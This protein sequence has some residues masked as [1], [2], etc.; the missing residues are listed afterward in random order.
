MGGKDG[1]KDT[2]STPKTL[3]ITKCPKNAPTWIENTLELC[4]AVGGGDAKWVG[5]V[6]IWM[7][8]QKKKGFDG[9]GR[10]GGSGRPKAI[11]DWLQRKRPAAFRPLTFDMKLYTNAF[12]TW[13][14]SLQPEAREDGEGEGFLMLSRPDVV[15]WSRLELFGINRIVS[16]VAGLAWWREKVYGLPSA[17]HCQRKFKE[18]EMQKFEEAL[19]DV[20]YVFGELKRV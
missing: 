12:R 15:D 17:E 5:F 20:T 8:L 13:W 14:R 6:N 11:S 2:V 7:A 4:T 3:T 16:I 1:G 19:D 18:E 10:L 9:E